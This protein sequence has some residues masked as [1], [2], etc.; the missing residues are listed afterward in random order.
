MSF[1]NGLVIG[2]PRKRF[3]DGRETADIPFEDLQVVLP[4]FQ[5]T[6]DNEDDEILAEFHNVFERREGDLGLHH[7]ELDEV[8]AGLGFLGPKGRTETVDLAE[9]RGRGLV[10][11]LAALAEIGLLVEVLR[12]EKRRRPFAGARRQDGRIHE[13]ESAAVEEVPDRFDDLGPDPEDGVLFLRT[14][15]QVSVLH[16]ERRAVLLQRDRIFLGHLKNFDL[17]DGE[18]V[19]SRRPFILPEAASDDDRGFLG[20]GIE[21]P[22]QRIF[23]FG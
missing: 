2:Q 11:E 14:Q 23:L 12:F 1:G 10:V 16:Q 8:T 22:E 4:F 19:A 21:G 18:L 15:P 3:S 13:T 6:F 20:Q 7:P 17:L 9:G 5:N